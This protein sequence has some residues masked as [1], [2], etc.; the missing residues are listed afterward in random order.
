MTL[1]NI[2]SQMDLTHKIPHPNITEY[3]FFLAA[4][5]F[6][7]DPIWEHKES[8]SICR[9]TE[10]SHNLSNHIGINLEINSSRNFRELMSSWRLNNTILNNIGVT[11]KKNQEAFWVEWEILKADLGQICVSLDVYIKILGAIK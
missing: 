7:I 2:T 3:I 5:N 4:Q 10:T 1:S 6:E 9:K 11:D 8:L